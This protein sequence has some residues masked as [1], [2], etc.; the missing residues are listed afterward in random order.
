MFTMLEVLDPKVF[1]INRP[2]MFKFLHKDGYL[3]WQYGLIAWVEYE[4]LKIIW[5]TGNK[6][7]ESI[8]ISIKELKTKNAEIMLLGEDQQ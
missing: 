6:D 2:V 8:Y 5:T 4:R 1:Y 3:D 7:P